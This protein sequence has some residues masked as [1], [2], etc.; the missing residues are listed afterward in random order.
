MIFGHG[1]DSARITSGLRRED[2]VIL[3]QGL[4]T[5]IGCGRPRSTQEAAASAIGR[6]REE[7]VARPAI[8]LGDR[9]ART[10]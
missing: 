7:S 5:L 9:G 10:A 3:V 4:M 2:S 1:G 6:Q 8:S